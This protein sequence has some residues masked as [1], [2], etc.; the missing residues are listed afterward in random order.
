MT[1]KMVCRWLITPTHKLHLVPQAALV[2]PFIWPNHMAQLMANHMGDIIGRLNNIAGL[3]VL[4]V[5]N[6]S[7][8]IRVTYFKLFAIHD[9]NGNI[10]ARLCGLRLPIKHLVDSILRVARCQLILAS[11]LIMLGMLAIRIYMLG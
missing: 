11:Q 3:A 6:T 10:W 9:S 5:R 1:A 4:G 8:P 7:P 2:R